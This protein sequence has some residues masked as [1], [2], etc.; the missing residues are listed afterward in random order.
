MRTV[1]ISGRRD[2]HVTA[3][4]CEGFDYSLT[5]LREEDSVS[6]PRLLVIDQAA[7]VTAIFGIEP[8]KR[9]LSAAFE[10]FPAPNAFF[11]WSDCRMV[12]PLKNYEKLS[13]SAD[14]LFFIPIFYAKTSRSAELC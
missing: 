9:A 13:V 3:C 5:S 14:T 2:R 11:V 8:V 10:L 7:F 6:H 12:N 4:I 1:A